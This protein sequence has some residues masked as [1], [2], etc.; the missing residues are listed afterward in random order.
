MSTILSLAVV[1]TIVAIILGLNVAA[2]RAILRD[3]YSERRQKILQTGLVWLLP[4]IGALVVLG[5]HRQPDKPSGGYRSYDDRVG[6]D[7]GKS[8]SGTRVIVEALDED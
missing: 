3:D 8:R 5:V 4:I 2:T 6:E 7:F 1:A